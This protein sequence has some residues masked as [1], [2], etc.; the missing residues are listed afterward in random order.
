MYVKGCTHSIHFIANQHI[1]L[2]TR[3]IIYAVDLWHFEA[4]I[5]SKFYI[6]Y[7][8]HLT[9]DLCIVNHFIHLNAVAS[10]TQMIVWIFLLKTEIANFC[11]VNFY[12]WKMKWNL[13]L[14]GTVQCK[15]KKSDNFNKNGWSLVKSMSI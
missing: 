10:I 14:D 7:W 2:E 1:K 9:I 12:I 13:F 4:I 15:Q 3:H 6:L 5:L 8:I 11:L